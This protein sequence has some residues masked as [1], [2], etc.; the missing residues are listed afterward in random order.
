MG[1]LASH[2][3]QELEILALPLHSVD[4]MTLQHMKK[5]SLF[6]TIVLATTVI[7]AAAT[8]CLAKK[9]KEKKR[10]AAIA[11]AGYE[12]AYDIHYPMK[13]RR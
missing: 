3:G 8:L 7:G 1:W 10:L 2:N 11:D 6:A 4:K 13:Y 5:N 9:N 12:L